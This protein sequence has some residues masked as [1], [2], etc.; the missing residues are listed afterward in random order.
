MHKLAGLKKLLIIRFSSIGDIVLTTP[1]IR[2]LKNQMKDSE[3]HYCTKKQYAGVLEANPYIYKLHLFDNSLS[4]LASRL[5]MEKFDYIVDLHNSL[6]SHLLRLMLAKSASTFPKLNLKKWLL[7]RFNINLLPDIHIVD[8]YF[9]SVAR[10]GI[11]NDGKGLDYFIPESDRFDPNWLGEAYQNGY[12][13]FVIGG[14]HS[15]K[16]FPVQKVIEVC[17][18]LNHPV[19]LL[20]GAEDFNNGENIAAVFDGKVLNSCGRYNLNRSASLIKQAGLIITNDT[21]LMHVAAAFNKKIISLWGNTVPAFGMYPYLPE[22]HQANSVIFEI[23]NLKCR[24][25]SKIGYSECPKQHF[26][27]MN[28]LDAAKISETANRM[29]QS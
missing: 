18:R 14:R 21:G 20:G 22:P 10:F 19:V 17:Q 4:E 5:K 27:C 28:N 12:I 25:C 2:C 13:G 24:P 23:N 8:R 29:M 7:V 6:R 9:E 11:I 15:T 26:A 16:I 3:I 1:V